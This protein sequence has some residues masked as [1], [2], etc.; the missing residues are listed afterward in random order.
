GGGGG[1][2]AGRGRGDPGGQQP[3]VMLPGSVQ[4]RLDECPDY[5]P[6]NLP[7][8]ERCDLIDDSPLL[9]GYR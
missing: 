4:R 5:R 1:G 6:C 3:R 7:A 8:L 9:D 2:G